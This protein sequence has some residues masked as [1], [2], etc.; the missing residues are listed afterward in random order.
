MSDPKGTKVCLSCE[1][2]DCPSK[3]DKSLGNIWGDTFHEISVENGHYFGECEVCQHVRPY[4]PKI[5]MR[6]NGAVDF[7]TGRVFNSR[8]D[9]RDFAKKNGLREV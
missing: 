4:K 8:Q 3:R 6:F 2:Y 5:P 1:N 7:S 9:Q